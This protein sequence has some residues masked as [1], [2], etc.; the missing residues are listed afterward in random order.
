VRFLV[1]ASRGTID[2]LVK[3]RWLRLGEQTTF[4]RSLLR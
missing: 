2:L 1:E 3:G 4:S